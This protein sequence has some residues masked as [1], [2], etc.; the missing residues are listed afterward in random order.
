MRWCLLI[1]LLPTLS[2]AQKYTT[3]DLQKLRLYSTGSFS[4]L[5]SDSSHTSSQTESLK[6]NSIWTK[7]KDGLWLFAERTDSIKKY[8]VWHYYF[9]DDTTLVLQFLDFKEPEKAIQLSKDIKWETNLK[10]F[11]LL[12]KHGCELYLK[13]GKSNFWGNSIGKD[14]LAENKEIEYLIFEIELNK[15]SIALGEAGYNKED[16]LISG[17]IGK[18]KPFVRT[19]KSPK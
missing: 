19:L 2:N 9:Q 14:C 10:I 7:R 8:Q 15:N 1:L 5:G 3:A 18:G 16:T 4:R 12:T 17:A 13:K 11:N 6:I